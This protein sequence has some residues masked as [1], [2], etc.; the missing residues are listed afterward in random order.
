M[1]LPYTSVPFWQ[2]SASCAD[3]RVDRYKVKIASIRKL[4]KGFV[5]DYN[6]ILLAKPNNIPKMKLLDFHVD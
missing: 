2:V 4:F 5:S 6:N 1:P 3:E